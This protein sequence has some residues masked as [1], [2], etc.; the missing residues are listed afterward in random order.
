[1]NGRPVGTDFQ[2][3][4]AYAEQ[5]DVH[6]AT[7]TVREAMQF[8]AY[9]RQPAHVSKEEKDAWVSLHLPAF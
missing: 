6:E 9:L 5:Q 7:A 8:S 3:S 4:C 2:R 1:M